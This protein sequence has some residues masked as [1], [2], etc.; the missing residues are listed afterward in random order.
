MIYKSLYNYCFKMSQNLTNDEKSLNKEAT[1]YIPSKNRI[2]DKLKLNLDAAEYKP[3]QIVEYVESEDDDDDDEQ[4]KE[5]IDMIIGDVVENEVMTELANE[6]K[7][8]NSD[9]SEDE[10]NWFPK[11]KDCPCCYGFVYKC[12]G[13]ACFSLGECYCKMKDDID[14]DRNEKNDINEKKEEIEIRN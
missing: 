7:L 8:D 14:E 9:D 1:E 11:Y 12:K 5:E 4:V 2:P 3:K 10:D 13:E 6:H